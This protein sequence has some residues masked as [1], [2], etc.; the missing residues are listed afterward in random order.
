MPKQGRRR[1]M[2]DG[3]KFYLKVMLQEDHCIT[4]PTMEL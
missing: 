2:V 3:K 4:I 1:I